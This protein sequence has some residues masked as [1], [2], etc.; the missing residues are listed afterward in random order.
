MHK[1]IRSMNKQV[2][3]LVGVIAS[4]VYVNTNKLVLGVGFVTNI[5]FGYVQIIYMDKIISVH[6]LNSN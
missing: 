3:I 6:H 1:Y 2:G 4:Y 5:V